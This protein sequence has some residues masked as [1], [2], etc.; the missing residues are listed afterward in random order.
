MRENQFGDIAQELLEFTKKRPGNEAIYENPEEIYIRNTAEKLLMH[1]N[2]FSNPEE[3]ALELAE[4]YT[5]VQNV[6]DRTSVAWQEIVRFYNQLMD[7]ER[8]RPHLKELELTER[9]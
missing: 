6:Q 1:T 2:G 9:L 4:I 7:N 8:L 3:V 5:D